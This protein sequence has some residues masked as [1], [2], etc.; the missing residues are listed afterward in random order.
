[1]PVSCENP[2]KHELRHSNAPAVVSAAGTAAAICVRLQACTAGNHIALAGLD[3]KSPKQTVSTDSLSQGAGPVST[4]NLRSLRSFA[5][6]LSG[7]LEPRKY[8]EA[9]DSSGN[10]S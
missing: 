1:M 8:A 10:V 4:T 9:I 5:R 3:S 7:G 6:S 2:R